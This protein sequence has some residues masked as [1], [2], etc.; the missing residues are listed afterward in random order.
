[1]YFLLI[2]V[3]RVRV[4]YCKVK[5]KEYEKDKFPCFVFEN[6]VKAPDGTLKDVYG[7]PSIE[8]PGMVKVIT[9]FYIHCQ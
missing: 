6:F 8:Y 1:M 4:N 7:L 9:R 5:T 2:Q 3:V